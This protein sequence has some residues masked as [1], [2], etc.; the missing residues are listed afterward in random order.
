[1]R[2]KLPLNARIASDKM[3]ELLV[4]FVEVFPELLSEQ[5]D[6][7]DPGSFDYTS[8]KYILAAKKIMSY[9]EYVA[10]LGWMAKHGYADYVESKDVED[11]YGRFLGF[12]DPIYFTDPRKIK[13]LF[14]SY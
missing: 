3:L 8:N 11:K 7:E 5:V 1:M 4:S 14:L 9:K 13:K 6:L 12:S 10:L 2:R